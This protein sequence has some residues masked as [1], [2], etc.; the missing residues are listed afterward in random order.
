MQVTFQPESRQWV[1]TRERFNIAPA[2]KVGAVKR[3]RA[4][5][6]SF[7][8]MFV[9][10]PIVGSAKYTPKKN[11]QNF[12]Q[13]KA[14]DVARESR[15]SSLAFGTSQISC[16]MRPLPRHTLPVSVGLRL[17]DVIRSVFSFLFVFA[18]LSSLLK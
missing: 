15:T 4:F 18:L 7:I 8:G 11:L 1:V 5:S 10:W 12:C 2:G 3:S 14:R 6:K 16:S 13:R 17:C 9:D